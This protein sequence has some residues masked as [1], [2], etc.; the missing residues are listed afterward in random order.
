MAKKEVKLDDV[1]ELM[2]EEEMR[3]KIASNSEMRMLLCWLNLPTEG[4]CNIG[5]GSQ[6]ADQIQDLKQS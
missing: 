4:G 6:A 2:L 5:M 1:K 3:K